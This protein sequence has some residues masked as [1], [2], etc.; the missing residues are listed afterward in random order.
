MADKLTI[1]QEKYAQG[2]FAGKSQREAYKEAFNCSN[3]S[4]KTIDEEACKLANSPKITARLL[5]LTN[6]LKERNMVTV[7]K[8]LSELAKVGFANGSDFA[9]VVEKTYMEPIPGEDGEETTYKEIKYK[10]VEVIPTEQLDSDK[11]AA[12][13]GIKSTRDGIEVKTND[14][15]KA[16]ELMGKHL[17]MFT[18][19]I[20][21]KITGSLSLSTKTDAELKAELA[22]ELRQKG[23]SD[24]EIE[25]IIG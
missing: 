15:I 4:D 18:D 6:E 13:S 9:R 11:L 22:A 10:A 23:V 3:M 7:E 1:K 20:E 17:G 16:L 8:V 25:K 14:K 24:A 21:Q 19:K 5:E 2:L 12:I